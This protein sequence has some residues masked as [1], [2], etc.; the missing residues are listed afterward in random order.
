MTTPR[1]YPQTEPFRRFTLPVTDGHELYVEQ[2]GNPE[3][4]PVVVLHGGPGAGCSPFMRRFFDPKRY[5][6]ILFDQRGAGKSTPSAGL[7]ANTTWDL[8]EDLERIRTHLEIDKWQLFGGSWGSTLALLYAQKYPECASELVL[9]GIFTM[10]QAELDWFYAGGAARF[11]PEAWDDFI[12]LIP[13]DERGNLIA[14]YHKRLTGDDEAEQVKFARPWVR[15]ENSTAVLRPS[16]GVPP[17]NGA[18]ARAFAR[19]ESHYFMNRGWLDRDDQILAGMPALEDI[20]GVIVQGRYDMICPPMVAMNVSNAWPT[21][22]LVIV[23][24]AG[25]ALSEPGIT[26]ALI[27]ATDKFLKE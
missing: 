19:I 16:R 21:A 27:E 17:M 2:C 20:P 11:F 24:D 6:I 1:L 10:S 8:V 18:Y 22:D 9:R 15:W 14:A 5:R 26:S 25:H 23:N 3:G 12:D 4:K 13:E 7:E